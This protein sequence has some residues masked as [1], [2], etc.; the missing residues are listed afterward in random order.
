MDVMDRYKVQT[1]LIFIDLN[2]LRFLFYT[3]FGLSNF[4][5]YIQCKLMTADFLLGDADVHF[6][7]LMGGGVTGGLINEALS[8]ELPFLLSIVEAKVLPPFLTTLT[9]AINEVL[10]NYPLLPLPSK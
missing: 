9:D 3:Y 4:G 1:S 10:L 2:D 8:A 6:N 5:K 7:N